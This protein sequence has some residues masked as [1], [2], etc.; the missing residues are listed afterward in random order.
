MGQTMTTTPNTPK[1]PLRHVS[2]RVPWHDNRW[3]GCVCQEPHYNEAC[4]IL[5]RIAETRDDKLEQAV[6]GQSL[7]E[8][9]TERWP[10][11]VN[12]RGTFMADF[13]FTKSHQ[14]PYQR[15]SPG[16]H[17][18]MQPTPLRFPVYSAPAVPFRWMFRETMEN[19]RDEY[20]LD[21]DPDRE[22]ELGFQSTWV[23]ERTNQLALTDCFFGHIKPAQSLAFFY[24][25]QVPFWDQS[26]RVLIGVGRVNHVGEATEYKSSDRRRLRAILWER[27]IQHSIRPGFS[28]GFLLPY[29]DALEFAME[30][31]DFN[32]SEIAAIAPNDAF[33]EFS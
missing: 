12:E 6:A 11:C 8:L 20:E 28:D 4:L 16:T 9:N 32:P 26:G 10:S 3:T 23:Q 13:E 27:M 33:S 25:K 1:Y 24:A 2:I 14:H 19:F 31:P 5:P 18:H 30:N 22:P 21:V 29:H 17:G 15:T 7:K